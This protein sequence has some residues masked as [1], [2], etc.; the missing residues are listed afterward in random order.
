[1]LFQ[2]NPVHGMVRFQYRTRDNVLKSINIPV[3]DQILAC[4]I[5]KIHITNLI[6][7]NKGTGN[8]LTF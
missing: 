6:R 7:E 2:L 3:H 1:M 8:A 4:I 5:L